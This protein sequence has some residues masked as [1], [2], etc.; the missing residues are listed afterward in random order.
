MALNK[1]KVIIAIAALAVVGGI[2]SAIG[3]TST[4]ETTAP[5]TSAPAPA[6]TT[7]APAPSTEP[8]DPASETPA[9]AKES[10][11]V[12]VADDADS[13]DIETVLSGFPGDGEGYIV[14][15]SAAADHPEGTVVGLEVETPLG[16]TERGVWILLTNGSVQAANTE[17]KEGTSAS[18]PVRKDAPYAL[19]DE[20]VSVDMTLGAN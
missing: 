13:A 14:L 15:D 19:D 17:T 3:N 6:A 16:T 1:K 11:P 10:V 18:W 12:Q 2:G 5:V 4:E 7:E 9:R 8:H 20:V